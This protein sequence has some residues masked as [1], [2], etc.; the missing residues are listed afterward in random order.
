V[1]AFDADGRRSEVLVES[2]VGS[3]EHPLPTGRL[4]EKFRRLLEAAPG[5]AERSSAVER[6]V[7]EREPTQSVRAAALLP[8]A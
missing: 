7:L 1:V 2:P 4:L 8:P 3:P 6:T 5:G